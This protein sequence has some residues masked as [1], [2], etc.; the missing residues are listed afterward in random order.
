VEIARAEI[1]RAATQ[2]TRLSPDLAVLVTTG[3]VLLPF[4]GTLFG[5]QVVKA[6]SSRMR[7]PPV[8]PAADA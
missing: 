2:L 3:F 1:A 4:R 6:R 5:V 7:G 8:L